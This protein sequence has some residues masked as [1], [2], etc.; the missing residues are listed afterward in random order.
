MEIAWCTNQLAPI[1]QLGFDSGSP[2]QQKALHVEGLKHRR[3]IHKTG[4]LHQRG[5]PGEADRVKAGGEG[6]HGLSSHVAL[7]RRLRSAWRFGRAR[8]IPALLI[9]RRNNEIGR[10]HV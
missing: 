1:P 3:G 10:A 4:G 9:W 7:G 8:R 2:L 6:R 5:Q